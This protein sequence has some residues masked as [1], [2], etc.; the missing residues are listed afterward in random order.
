MTEKA[1][2]DTV[3][4][5]VLHHPAQGRVAKK[6]QDAFQSGRPDVDYCNRGFAALIELKYADRWPPRA[7][8]FDWAGKKT[9]Y[10]A[11]KAWLREWVVSGGGNGFWL[12]GVKSEWLLLPWDTPCP[13][14]RDELVGLALIQG[15]RADLRP[16][17]EYLAT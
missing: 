2:W 10:P 3:I 8:T 6:V 9:R 13:A 5:P 16:L 1:W 15:A 4:Q 7:P 14:G 12:L 17:V 11:Q